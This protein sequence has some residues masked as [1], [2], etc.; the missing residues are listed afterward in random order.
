MPQCSACP[1]PQASI[2]TSLHKWP[3]HCLQEGYIR[4]PLGSGHTWQHQGFEILTFTKLCAELC[5]SAVSLAISHE[6]LWQRVSILYQGRGIGVGRRDPE[7]GSWL[8]DGLLPSETEQVPS[9]PCPATRCLQTGWAVTGLLGT[10]GPKSYP[11]SSWVS[12]CPELRVSD[13]HSSVVVL[14]EP[15]HNCDASWE[16]VD[17]FPSV[18]RLPNHALQEIRG[19]EAQRAFQVQIRLG[20]YTAVLSS[21]CLKLLMLTMAIIIL[22]NSS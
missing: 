6:H 17:R 14:W 20:L 2:H 5:F 1:I 9:A 13:T 22:L 18:E 16:T 12:S 21:K 10:R 7:E 3:T 8:W 19:Y 4:C 15:V 11:P